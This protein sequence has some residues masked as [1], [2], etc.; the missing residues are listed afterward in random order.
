MAKSS[1]GRP[2]GSRDYCA[3]ERID[4]VDGVTVEEAEHQTA[5]RLYQNAARVHFN[6]SQGFNQRGETVI[7]YVRWVMVRKRDVSAPAAETQVLSCPRRS[8]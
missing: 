5:T 8:A 4:H 2:F 6:R 3:R 7:D 1:A